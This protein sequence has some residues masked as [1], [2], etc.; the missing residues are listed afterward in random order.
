MNTIKRTLFTGLALPT[1]LAPAFAYSVVAAATTPGNTSTYYSAETASATSDSSSSSTDSQ[2]LSNIKTKGDAE[3]NR[4]LAALGTLST[5]ISNA[6]KLTSADKSTLLGEVTAEI[7]GLTALK[8]K[9]D[10]ETT[11]S[12]AAA[13]VQNMVTEYRV[14]ALIVPKIQFVRMADNQQVVQSKLTALATKL[15]TRITAAQT[16]GKDVALLQQQLTQLQSIV[17]AAGVVSSSVEAKVIVLQPSDYNSD[18]S[19]LSGYNEQLKS[20]HQQNQTAYDLAKTMVSELKA[21]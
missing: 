18:H 15:Q 20:V 2:R 11:V 1:L 6:T 8:A 5:K 16:A 9:L 4:R 3:I 19:T 14:Y 7:S 17:S 13:D 10:A 12:A 21:L